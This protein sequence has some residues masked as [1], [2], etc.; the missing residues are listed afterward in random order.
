MGE[1]GFQQNGY[2]LGR[3]RT[4]ETGKTTTS[5]LLMGVGGAIHFPKIT[6]YLGVSTTMRF[7]DHDK[8]I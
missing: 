7:G 2:E 6:V 8:C 3:F 1:I 5:Q 4:L